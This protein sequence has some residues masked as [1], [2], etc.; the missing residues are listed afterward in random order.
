MRQLSSKATSHYDEDENP[1]ILLSQRPLH[2]DNNERAWL[3]SK[4]ASTFPAITF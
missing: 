3:C 2:N 4:V 1:F